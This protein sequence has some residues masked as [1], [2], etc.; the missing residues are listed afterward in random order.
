MAVFNRLK[1]KF[2]CAFKGM[3]I[4]F[5]TENSFKIHIAALLAVIAGAWFLDFSAVQWCLIL[6]AVGLVFIS[7]LFNT[8]IEYLV[9]M[10]T[11]EYH[12]LAEKLLDI[13]AGAVL[14]SSITASVIGIILFFTKI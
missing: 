13:S 12:E 14:F 8:S 4:A 11:E 3:A 7:E 9:K 1:K 10:F 5:T 2:G 6:I